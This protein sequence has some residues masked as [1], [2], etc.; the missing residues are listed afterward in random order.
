MSNAN[1][2]TIDLESE[3][4]TPVITTAWNVFSNLICT[5]LL[6]IAFNA[7]PEITKDYFIEDSLLTGTAQLQVSTTEETTTAIDKTDP[8]KIKDDD[9]VYANIT[10]RNHKSIKA[11]PV[12]TYTL[13]S[14]VYCVELTQ[15]K[16]PNSSSAL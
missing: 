5:L 4:S 2:H 11:P 7:Q 12:Q 1:K 3:P 13:H 14:V 10:D 16:Q 6:P 15:A 8:N 9:T